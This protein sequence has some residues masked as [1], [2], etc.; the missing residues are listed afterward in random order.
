M[1]LRAPTFGQLACF[2][3]SFDITG[4]IPQVGGMTRINTN[5]ILVL[6]QGASFLSVKDRSA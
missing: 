5:R 2:S 1:A 6:S 4:T 3:S